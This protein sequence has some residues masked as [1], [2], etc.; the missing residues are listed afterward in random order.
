MRIRLFI[1]SLLFVSCA[2]KKTGIVFGGGD[3]ITEMVPKPAESAVNKAL[4]G[5]I[6]VSRSA[7][8]TSER[9]VKRELK[10]KYYR[11]YIGFAVD[12]IPPPMERNK[13]DI[14]L[15]KAD[16]AIHRYAE[17]RT[18]MNTV[19]TIFTLISACILVPVIGPLLPGLSSANVFVFILTFFLLT[20]ILGTWSM[21]WLY[22]YLRPELKAQRAC[23]LIRRAPLH[24]PKNRF[25]EYEVRSLLMLDNYVSRRWQIKH[26]RKLREISQTDLYNPWLNKIKN[27]RYYNESKLKKS[28]RPK[29]IRINL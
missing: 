15:S 27:L 7:A 18:N 29:I 19:M 24:A 11:D 21:L 2:T 9:K 3:A 13:A 14:K 10:K 16:R 22:L 20:L 8:D 23:R 26:I 5:E 25:I 4:F 12:T 28:Q 6:S 17:I 1:I